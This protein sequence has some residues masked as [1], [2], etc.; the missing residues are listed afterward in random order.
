MK[1][2]MLS[3][4]L[5][6]FSVVAAAVIETYQFDTP[7]QQ[8][9]YHAFTQE[10]RCPKCQNQNLSGSDSAISVDLRRQ[11][12]RMIMDDKSDIEITQYMVDR[13]GNFILY[14]PRFSAQTAVLWF[15]P[16]GLLILGSLVWWRMASGLKRRKVPSDVSLSTVE[17]ARLQELL[18]DDVDGKQSGGRS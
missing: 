8:K 3:W 12:H 16:L 6:V 14:R 9:R 13:Y 15:T 5:M 10:L 7:L 1:A 18:N 17:Q 11:I 2:I 4:V